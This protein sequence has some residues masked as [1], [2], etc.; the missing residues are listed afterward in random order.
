MMTPDGLFREQN[1]PQNIEVGHLSRLE[2]MASEEAILNHWQFAL[3]FTTL[4]SS[5]PHLVF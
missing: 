4:R 3:L 5:P 2:Q 1:S